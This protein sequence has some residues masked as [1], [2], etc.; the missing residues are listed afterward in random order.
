MANE[1]TDPLGHIHIANPFVTIPNQFVILSGAK[2]LLL[3][4]FGI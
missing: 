2:D 1:W 3:L 4:S